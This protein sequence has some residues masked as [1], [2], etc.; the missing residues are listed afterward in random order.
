MPEDAQPNDLRG[1]SLASRIPSIRPTNTIPRNNHFSSLARTSYK[2]PSDHSYV[3]VSPTKRRKLDKSKPVRKEIVV[4]LP[5]ACRK[6]QSGCHSLRKEFIAHETDRLQKSGRG[7]TVL[8]HAVKDEAIHFLCT[9]D[10]LLNCVLAP[11]SPMKKLQQKEPIQPKVEPLSQILPPLDPIISTLP[12]PPRC[13]KSGT[14]SFS[15][16]PVEPPEERGVVNRPSSAFDTD[17]SV[18][19]LMFGK[20]GP[21]KPPLSIAAASAPA[22]AMNH[23]SVSSSGSRIVKPV[24]LQSQTHAAASTVSLPT[25]AAATKLPSSQPIPFTGALRTPLPRIPSPSPANVQTADRLPDFSHP[26]SSTLPDNPPRLPQSSLHTDGEEFRIPFR[27]PQDKLR[28]FLCGTSP[29]SSLLVSMHGT[30]EGVEVASRKHWLVAQGPTPIKEAVDD[31]CVVA[32]GNRSIVILAHSRDE[33]QLSL[34]NLT[35]AA[36]AIDLKRPWNTAKK[37]GVSAVAPLLQPLMFAS[38]G[39]DHAA[40]LWTIKDDLSSASPQAT[41]IKHSS[42]IQSL[43]ALRDTSHKLVSAGA[44]CSVNIWDLSSERV[45]NTLKLSNSVYHLHPT[46]SPFCTLFEVAHRELQFEIRD[47]RHVPT[48]PV[49]RFGYKTFQ[50]HGRYMKGSSIS[51]SFASGDR[52]GCVRLWDLRNVEEPCAEIECFNGLKISHVVFQ[53][54]RLLACAENNQIRVVKYDRSL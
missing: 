28:R 22:P 2:R 46:T 11:S 51:H 13:F 30:L 32:D 4:E 27:T 25:T 29:A 14:L 34:I 33:Q 38:G 49:Q 10:D 18:A 6:G 50:V 43:L 48:I 24:P 39:Y 8:G 12:G 52:A 36:S 3:A 1:R 20:Q 7:L 5:S 21:P 17:L 19:G 44:D 35:N 45:V 54:S 40:H 23:T 26:T 42:Q 47:H 31:A 9:Q 53:S 37:G 41:T 16:E 15:V